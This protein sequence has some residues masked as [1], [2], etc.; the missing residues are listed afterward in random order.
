V[1]GYV[2][3][4]VCY[5]PK[6]AV[7]IDSSQHSHLQHKSRD[8]KR[9]AHLRVSGFTVLRFWNRDIDEN[10]EGVT[11]MIL[12]ELESNTPTPAA[13]TRRHLS[14]RGGGMEC[15]TAAVR[16]NSISGGC[17]LDRGQGWPHRCQ[18]DGS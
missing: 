14:P 13:Q 2:I 4:F 12:H 15:G 18:L 11:A 6:V 1:D 5:H 8:S 9:D 16:D 7:E 10:L 17:A 3:D